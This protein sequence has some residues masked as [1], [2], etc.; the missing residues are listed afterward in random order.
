MPYEVDP[1]SPPGLACHSFSPSSSFSLTLSSFVIASPPYCF[2]IYLFIVNK[3]IIDSEHVRVGWDFR[4][5]QVQAPDLTRDETQ[6]QKGELF[7]PKLQIS[8]ISST[9]H[10][11]FP[12]ESLCQE[13]RLVSWGQHSQLGLL[14]VPPCKL[15]H[16]QM[17]S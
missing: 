3:L 8:N 6:A 14:R 2:N 17:S 10:A 15:L 16:S 11:F 5:Y 13:P 12:E 4:K 9:P 1:L 7:C